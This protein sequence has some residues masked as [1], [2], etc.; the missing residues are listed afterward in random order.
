MVKLKAVSVKSGKEFLIKKYGEDAVMGVINSLSGELKGVLSSDFII[1]SQWILMDEWMDF[2]NLVV[3]N[4]A[5]GDESVMI[6]LGEYNATKELKGIY[7][8]FLMVLSPEAII[9]R[10]PRIF[11]TYL[12]TQNKGG[13]SVKVIS[14]GNIL[15]TLKG[16]EQGHRCFELSSIGWC[17]KALQLAG[18]K[19]V[20]VKVAKSI[21]DGGDYFELS[22]VWTK[23]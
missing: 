19:D 2:C 17:K 13:G 22:A 14:S 6:D 23:K 7:S 20:V 15:I 4:L 9:K 10:A 8:V 16:L 18:A 21:E 11:S 12:N 3:K 5:G 1:S